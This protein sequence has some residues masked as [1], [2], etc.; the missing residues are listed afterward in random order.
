MIGTE[1]PGSMSWIVSSP[2][3][4]VKVLTLVPQEVTLFGNRVTA[5]IITIWSY[6]RR[7]DP[8]SNMPGVLIKRGRGG[9]DTH[10]GENHMKVKAEIGVTQQKASSTK[11]CQHTPRSQDGPGEKAPHSLRWKPAWQHPDLTHLAIVESRISV[12][13]FFLI[14]FKLIFIA[15]QWLY[16]TV[17]VST[18]TAKRIWVVT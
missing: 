18:A 6:W 10:M 12:F 17:S 8:W 11:D 9:R 15:I 3:S 4:N 14:L 16:N 5:R 13:L 7:T 1:I 2:D